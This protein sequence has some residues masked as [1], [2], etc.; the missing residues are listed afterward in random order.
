[1]LALD[2]GVFNRKDHAVSFREAAIMSLIWVTCSLAFYAFLTVRGDLIHNI[3]DFQHLQ[4]VVL[5]HKHNIDL[6]AGN[7]AESLYLYR[8][9][10]AL[11]YFIGYLVEYEMT[12][13]D[14]KRV[15]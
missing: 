4:E 10:L 13:E 15:V 3:T 5:K 9:K 8:K 1:M 7:F 11:E 6:I 12:V 2:L 14:R